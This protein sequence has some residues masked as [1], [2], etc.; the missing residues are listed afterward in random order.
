MST[1]ND[2][3]STGLDCAGQGW[4]KDASG[5]ISGRDMDRKRFLKLGGAGVAGAMLA[6]SLPAYTLGSSIAVAQGEAGTPTPGADLAAE[7]E[8]AAR[9]Y[10]VSAEVL[11][12]MGYINTRWE[13]PPPELS[14][15]ED[16]DPHGWGGHGIMALVRNPST[17]TL[18]EASELTGIPEEELKTDRRSNILGGAALLAQSQA[19]SQPE[20][21]PTDTLEWIPRVGAGPPS[22][23]E[24]PAGVGGGELYA[25]QV[26]EAVSQGIG[27]GLNSRKGSGKSSRNGG[28]G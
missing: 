7:F 2:G 14:A 24:P 27:A 11:A 13:M 26:R 16:G 28:E 19:R 3:V 8:E 25:E 18:G 21:E 1:E 17:N 5:M 20:P 4:R 9:E 15:Y 22:T 23:G 10:G 12:A 6:G